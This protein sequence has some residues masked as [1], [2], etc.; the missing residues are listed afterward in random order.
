M[1]NVIIIGCD[2]HDESMLLK[3]AE[4]R[5]TPHVRSFE[6]TSTGRKRMIEYLKKQAEA[7]GNARIV[8]AYEASGQGFGLYDELTNAEVECHVLAPTKIARSV[9]QKSQ[10]TDE[11]DAQ[12][13][14]ELLRAY[15]LAG[16]ALPTVWVPDRQT[17]DDRELVR[18]RL[19]VSD[20]SVSLKAQV[21]SLL[22]RNYLRRP[23]GSGKGWTRRFWGWLQL[24]LVESED[25][26]NCP[27]D[28]TA[29]APVLA[30]CCD[31][32]DSW[33]RNESCSTRR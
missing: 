9:R 29:L 3:I 1:R 13:L 4:G 16:N 33:K 21:Q 19:D 26:E 24:S 14:L 5:N 25:P 27:L 12:Q 20:K 7:A 15:V 2:L 31:S 6:N 22:K 17:R 23:K 8:F 18:M 11:K 30:A 10:K 32:F 28:F